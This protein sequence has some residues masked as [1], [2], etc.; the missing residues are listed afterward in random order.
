MWPQPTSSRSKCLCSAMGTLWYVSN[1]QIH[2]SLGVPYIAEHMRSIA[3]SLDSTLPTGENPQFGN[4]GARNV[5][6]T[7]N[8]VYWSLW[9]A[10]KLYILQEMLVSTF[11]K[12]P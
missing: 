3:H 1:L 8:E 5:L 12:I 9:T 10:T 11:L 7:F 2:L 4:L 6:V